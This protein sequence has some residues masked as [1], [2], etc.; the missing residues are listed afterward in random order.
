MG[1]LV[2]KRTNPCWPLFLTA[3]IFIFCWALTP[4]LAEPAVK[5]AV[6]TSRPLLS[7]LDPASI[8]P[9]GTLKAHEGRPSIFGRPAHTIAF[10]VGKSY[11]ELIARLREER[12]LQR[13][14]SFRTLKEAELFVAMALQKKEIDIERFLNNSKQKRLVLNVPLNIDTGQIVERKTKHPRAGRGVRLVL[15]KGASSKEL[16]YIIVTSFPT[17]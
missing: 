11:D 4:V 15:D 10:H 8:I 3:V 6:G 16:R 5:S 7:S 13:V 2:S 9:G 17:F 1:N 14:S 12:G